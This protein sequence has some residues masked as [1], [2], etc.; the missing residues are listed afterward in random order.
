MCV[1]IEMIA[2]RCR[3]K[4]N[5]CRWA[6]ERMRLKAAAADYL[7]EIAPRDREIFDGGKLCGCYLWM[8]TPSTPAPDDWSGYEI[9][10]VCFES[11]A[12]A[13]TVFLD[14][15]TIVTADKALFNEWLHLAAEAQSA[16]RAGILRLGCLTD[17]DQAETFSWIREICATNRIYIER[18]M[19]DEDPA[20]LDE[21]GL[22]VK[23]IDQLA[24][25]VEERAVADRTKRRLF[26][27]CRYQLEEA[28]LDDSI[29]QWESFAATID[30]LVMTGTQ[31]SSIALRDLLL[32]HIEIIPRLNNLH[33]GFELALREV[34]RIETTSEA[35]ISDSAINGQ[36]VEAAAALLEGQAAVL[37]GGDSRASAKQ[38]LEQELRLSELCWVAAKHGQPVST[39]EPFIARSDV[40][41]V[42]LAIRWSSH[43][44][45][46]VRHLC[47]QFGKPLVRLKAGYSPNQV[48]A[49][50]LNQS[51]FRLRKRK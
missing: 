39:F 41:V 32:P 6:T 13:L 18:Y 16:L 36:T 37:I 48:A 8:S 3:L 45:T 43:A 23:R 25:R 10:A 46:A 12:A 27:K 14:N 35:Q 31:A 19:R 4:A 29:H 47:R 9:V 38:A 33:P 49:Q 34:K 40:K 26:Q 7:T 42:L 44:F 28:L 15:Q 51:S 50:I 24:R 22:L 30:Q 11:L 17:Q 1:P 21:S 20:K 5:A 2:S